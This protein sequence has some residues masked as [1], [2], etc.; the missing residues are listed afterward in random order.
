MPP[1]T[2]EYI[3]EQ[4]AIN[5]DGRTVTSHEHFREM[6]KKEV[7]YALSAKDKQKEEAVAEENN[8]IAKILLAD[9]NKVVQAVGRAMATPTN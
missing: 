6:V 7:L 1:K 3:A 9:E 8:R 4:V 5:L 2:N